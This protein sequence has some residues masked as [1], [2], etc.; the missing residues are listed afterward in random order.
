VAKF[1]LCGPPRSGK[2]CLRQGLKDAIKGIPGAPYPYV[3]TACPDGEGAWFQETVNHDA[4]LAARLKADYKSKFTPEFVARVSASV[5]NCT[6][7]LTLVDIGGIPS[8]EN[9]QICKDATHAVLLA[10]DMKRL[11]EWRAFCETLGLLIVAE[12]NSAYNGTED[13]VETV[14]SDGILRGSVHHLER[15]QPIVSRPM[16]QALA[17][18]LIAIAGKEASK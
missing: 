12:I 18:H 17:A 7:S 2:S 11:P 6:L 5:T 15:G 1:V 3:I 14:G 4:E 13:R 9:E 8:V 10:G 16:V